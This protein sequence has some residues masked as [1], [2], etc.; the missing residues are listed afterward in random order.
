M[1]WEGPVVRTSL[2]YIWN[3]FWFQQFQVHKI[4]PRSWE[5]YSESGLIK[6]STVHK[7][8][9][10]QEQLSQPP[11]KRCYCTIEWMIL[12]MCILLSQM[13]NNLWVQ[14]DKDKNRYVGWGWGGGG[15]LQAQNHSGGSI[16]IAR[17]ELIEERESSTLTAEVIFGR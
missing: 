4:P 3:T 8:Q 1:V 12:K 17:S 16:L 10:P 6:I 15:V 9:T 2:F 11:Q 7:L 5:P 13:W 14:Q